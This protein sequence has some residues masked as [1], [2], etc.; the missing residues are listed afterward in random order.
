[1]QKRVVGVFLLLLIIPLAYSMSI[2]DLVSR[3]NFASASNALNVTEAKDFMSDRDGNGLNDTLVFEL[4]INGLKGEYVIVI[5]L[6]DKNGIL[7][8]ETRINLTS[9]IFKVNLTLASIFLT[10]EQFN[11]SIK[12][13][14]SSYSLKYRKDNILTQSY[15]SFEEGFSLVSVSGFQDSKSLKIN[16]TVN[17]SING[18]F[19]AIAFL[20]YNNSVI[21]AEENV[22]LTDTLQDIIFNFN[23]ETVKK[24]HYSGNFALKSISIGKKNFKFDYNTSSYD[25]RDFSESSYISGFSDEGIDENGNGKFEKLEIESGVQVLEEGDYTLQIGIYG[26]FENL[27]ELKNTSSSLDIGQRTI[28]FIVNGSRIYSKKLD[29]PYIVKFAKLYNKGILLDQLNDYYTTKYY[30]FDDFDVPNLPDLTVNISPSDAYHYGTNNITVNITIRNIGY[31]NAFN[32]FADVFDNKTFEISNKSN[33]IAP[34]SKINYILNMT[35]MQDFELVALVDSAN[36][37]EETDESNNAEIIKIKINKKPKLNQVNNMTANEMETVL[38]NLTAFD[39]NDDN[40]TFNINSSRF[41]GTNGFFSWNT[42][43]NDSGKF[44]LLAV[45]SD[46]YLN[47][48]AEFDIVVKDAFNNDLDNDGINDSID[49]LIGDAGSINTSTLNLIVLVDG[50]RNL[51]R[52]FASNLSVRFLDNNLTVLE[53][54]F[55]FSKHRLN[56]SNITIN[57]QLPGEKGSMMVRGLKMPDKTLKSMYVDR[58]NSSL[59]SVCV[60]DDQ[61]KSISDISKKCSLKGEKKVKCNGKKYSTFR[62]T[63]DAAANRYKVYNLKHSGAVQILVK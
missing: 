52:F 55:N 37:V 1:M 18:S 36:L 19:D 53:F 39:P 49:N 47:D 51:S 11:Y 42:S 54:P 23:N 32:V 20:S 15:N 22:L 13:Y 62:C 24:T 33:L 17:S 2:K 5:S 10:K 60:K 7:T 16:A 46:G 30:T 3:Y 63:Y 6:L 59:N 45:A 58:I 12:I 35:N 50:S 25:Y 40:L 8:N 9:G 26:L 4:T 28:P 44:H 21:Y 41:S 34:G 38:V 27:L 61:I 43:L 31:K 29:G 48:S 14:N 56:L 57:K